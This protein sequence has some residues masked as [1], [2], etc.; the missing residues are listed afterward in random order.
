[1]AGM[2]DFGDFDD[3]SPQD[4]QD[5]QGTVEVT[6]L[7]GS[8]FYV[9]NQ[10]E[11]DYFED[12]S[13]RYVSD[14]R[15]SNTSDLQD[16]DRILMM[17][18]MVYRWGRWLALES[19]YYNNE[20][21]PEK[22][23][24]A[25]KEFSMEIRQLKKAVGLDRVSRD[26]DKGESIAAYIENLRRRAQEFGIMRNESAVKAITL[27]HDLISLVTLADNCTEQERKE[28]HVEDADIVQ[29]VR[30]VTPEFTDIDKE[31]RESSQQ[32]WVQSM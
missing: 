27:F 18:T 24:K 19:D 7:S 32:Y 9:L 25:I 15:F 26:K 14:N 4:T 1:M 30:D 17:E 28:N 6:T 13:A 3:Y 5:S 2:D 10:E 11:K 20:I 16:L 31:F 29:W 22:L 8:S 21:D 12:V 23:N